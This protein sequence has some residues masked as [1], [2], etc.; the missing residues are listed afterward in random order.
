MIFDL[1]PC[2]LLLIPGSPVQI[3]MVKDNDQDGTVR[4]N[5]EP[6]QTGMRMSPTRGMVW[7]TRSAGVHQS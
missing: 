2:R 4:L 7:P 5:L 3:G 6:D 1:S